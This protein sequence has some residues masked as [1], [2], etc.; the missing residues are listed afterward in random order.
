MENDQ[1][2]DSASSTKRKGSFVGQDDNPDNWNHSD[3]DFNGQDGPTADGDA[4]DE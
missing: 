2:E 3:N 4:N 1:I